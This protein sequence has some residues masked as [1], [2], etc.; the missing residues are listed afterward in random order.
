VSLAIWQRRCLRC[1]LPHAGRLRC[2]LPQP[3]SR[4]RRSLEGAAFPFNLRAEGASVEVVVD[5]PIAYMKAYT[6]VGPTNN[7]PRRRRSLLIALDWA[8]PLS[9]IR[10]A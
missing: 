7:H 3:L 2:A 6:V 1:A 10:L 4:Y 5:K 8:L 9:C